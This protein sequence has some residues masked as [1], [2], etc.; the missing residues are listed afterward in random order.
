MA[1]AGMHRSATADIPVRVCY[2]V[3]P[4]V[5]L[6]TLMEIDVG[7]QASPEAPVRG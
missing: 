6:G 7:A 1:L 3:E 2:A 5:H 4:R